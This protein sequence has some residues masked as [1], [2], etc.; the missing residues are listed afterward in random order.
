VLRDQLT[1]SGR[2]YDVSRTNASCFQLRLRLPFPAPPYGRRASYCFDA[3]TGAPTLIE[4]ERIEGRDR[5]QAVSVSAQVDDA[6][7][8][9]PPG[10]A[11]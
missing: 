2:I 10:L 8:A 1:G 3:A 5:Q 4:I 7:L 6:D 11:G 9:P